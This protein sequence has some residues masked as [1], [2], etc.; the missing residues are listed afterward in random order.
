MFQKLLTATVGLI[1]MTASGINGQACT[2]IAGVEARVGEYGLC[3]TVGHRMRPGSQYA[4]CVG[5]KVACYNDTGIPD[6]PQT[7]PVDCIEPAPG[8]CGRPNLTT[9]TTN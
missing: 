4:Y 5:G 3:Y 1:V 9:G 8:V 6:M 2:S 7:E